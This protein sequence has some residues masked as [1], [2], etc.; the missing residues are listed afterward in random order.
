MGIEMWASK[1]HENFEFLVKIFPLMDKSLWA[2]FT[3]LVAGEG[4]PGP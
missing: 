2:I 3:K 4:V 1:N